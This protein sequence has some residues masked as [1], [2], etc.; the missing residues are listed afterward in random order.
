M[1]AT[2]CDLSGLIDNYRAL[3]RTTKASLNDNSEEAMGRTQTFRSLHWG[4]E[5]CVQIQVEG[6]GERDINDISAQKCLLLPKQEWYT[7]TVASLSTLVVLAMLTM[8]LCVL[9]C[10]VRLPEKT[11]V[12]LKS[13]KTGWS[14]LVVGEGNMEVVTDKG[15]L[16]SMGWV[17]KVPGT[18]HAVV[19]ETEWKN[20]RRT[21]MDSGVSVGSNGT[22]KMGG[23]DPA[24]LEDS[25]CAIFEGSQGAE[26]FGSAAVEEHHTQGRCVTPVSAEGKTEDS[27]DSGDSGLVDVVVGYRK[28]QLS[29][30]PQMNQGSW[31]GH[32]ELPE[33]EI[34]FSTNYR[35]KTHI[36]METVVSVDDSESPSNWLHAAFEEESAPLF[37]PLMFPP[38]ETGDL[39]CA[40]NTV[41]ISICDVELWSE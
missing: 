4:R 30:M 41:P 27:G 29:C 15:W 3:H 2:H 9:C 22:A 25:G 28:G 36:Q 20:E 21:S 13:P 32:A 24:K 7:I 6:I 23:S 40:M 1:Q 31:P 5:Y 35:R 18:L 16:L 26:S 14:P 17:N 19:Q 11:P 12:A 37:L 10:F 38:L 8:L 34:T 33:E 39:G